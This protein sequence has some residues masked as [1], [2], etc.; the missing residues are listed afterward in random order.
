MK[1][2]IKKNILIILGAILLFTLLIL[3][4]VN[5]SISPLEKIK[6]E[7]VSSDITNYFFEIDNIDNTEIDKY[8]NYAF[9]YNLN[10]ND[11]K[12]ISIDEMYNIISSKFKV[13]LKKEDIESIGI[14]PSMALKGI[15]F[16]NDTS[17]FYINDSKKSYAEIASTKIYKYNIK[18]IKKISNKKYSIIYDKYIIE[19]PY[20]VL[21]YYN[22]LSND[23]K[24]KNKYLDIANKISSYLK[25]DGTLKDII[26]YIDKD[27]LKKCGKR[28]KKIKITFIVKDGNLM[29]NSYK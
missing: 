26:P 12:S 18:K 10:E 29:V 21:N 24:N 6:L 1:E 14:T 15:M 4:I 9:S 17:E 3:L 11:K 7:E 25:G 19:N 22:E 5:K 2:F 8:I 23:E 20:E 28:E 16:N 13:N 27:V